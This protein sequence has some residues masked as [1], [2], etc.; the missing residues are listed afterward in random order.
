MPNER[1]D[2]FAEPLG[3]FLADAAAGRPTPGGGSVAALAGALGV[4]LAQMAAHYTLKS[5][6]CAEHHDQARTVLARLERAG[7]ALRQLVAED[8]DAYAGYAAARKLPADAPDRI[9]AARVATLVPLEMVALLA[10]ALDVMADL[11]AVCNP[12]LKSDLRGGAAL[13]E[14]A[15]RA[16][17]ENVRVNLPDLES[18]EADETRANVDASLTRAAQART[19]IEQSA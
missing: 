1:P 14:A 6:R 3:R 16:A 11:S 18:A 2:Y 10:A 15:A 4:A 13:A 5:K 17:A 7:D 9:A 8:M 12:Y 19:R